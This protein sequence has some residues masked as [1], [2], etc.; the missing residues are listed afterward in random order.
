MGLD[1]FLAIFTKTCLVTLAETILTAK[2]PGLPDG[3]FSNQN[4]QFG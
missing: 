1:T 3:V 2:K 4:S